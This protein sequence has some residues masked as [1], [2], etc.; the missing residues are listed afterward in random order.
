[1]KCKEIA[2]CKENNFQTNLK[3]SEEI[4]KNYNKKRKKNA[5]AN[6]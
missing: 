6:K 5:K 3:I 1:M 2:S 4:L